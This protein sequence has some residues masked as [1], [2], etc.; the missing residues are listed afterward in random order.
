MK[1][2]AALNTFKHNLKKIY[3]QFSWKL[4]VIGLLLVFNYVPYPFIDL[5]IYLLIYQFIFLSHLFSLFFLTFILPIYHF[6]PPCHNLFCIIYYASI[7]FSHDVPNL[8]LLML[9]HHYL[10]NIYIFISYKSIVP[11]IAN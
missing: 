9:Q 2:I 3:W 6:L 11:L 8:L 7:S 1:N 5:F 4:G 10:F